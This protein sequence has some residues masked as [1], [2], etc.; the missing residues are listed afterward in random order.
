MITFII[1]LLILFVG[2]FFYSTI[3]DKV[4]KPTNNPTPAYTHEDGIDFVPM[5]RWKTSLINLL[6][7]AGTGPILGPIQG[8]LFGPIALILIPIGCVL[9][10]AI[11]DFFIGMVALRNDGAQMTDLVKKYMDN[12]ISK[13]YIVFICFL[14]ALVGAVFIYTPADILA[15]DILQIN[16]SGLNPII[17]V[18]YGLIFVY[19]II[20]TL[21]PID[22]IIGRIYPIFGGILLISTLGIF[23]GIFVKGYPLIDISATNLWGVNVLDGTHIIPTFFVTV[24]CGI[25]SGFHS[26]QITLISRNI[27]SEHYAKFNFYWIMIL[28]GFIAMVWAA[29][30]MGFYVKNN[31][32]SSSWHLISG[33]LP[34]PF[35][36]VGN[37]AFDMLGSVGG[38]IA[39]IGIIILPI[40]S[41]DT[42]LRGLRLMLNGLL[43]LDVKNKKNQ[44]LLT[45]GIFIVVVTILILAKISP[46]GFTLLWRYFSWANQVTALFAFGVSTIYLIKLKKFKSSL[47]VMIPGAFY[48]FIV[49]SFIFNSEIGFNLSLSA[50]YVIGGILSILYC[51]YMVFYGKKD[52]S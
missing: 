4:W 35:D 32:I 3:C 9:G 34:S 30:A 2:G 44:I 11:H 6:N 10:G 7:I 50:S 28:E 51:V 24:A 16:T 20:A 29:A 41:G 12:K 42:A 15:S 18:L 39:L 27:K 8:I 19:Y 17:W 33:N 52:L 26:T 22:K 48:M 43:N 49:A 46:D 47:M 21:L 5:P 31:Y 36:L 38:I 40:T 1:G 13:I 25:V 45:M 14:T 23:I 37:V